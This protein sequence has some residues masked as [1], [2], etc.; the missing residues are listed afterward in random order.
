MTDV[1][2]LKDAR[3]PQFPLFGSAT[4]HLAYPS[5]T[6]AR[7]LRISLRSAPGR[8]E[9]GVPSKYGG[10]TELGAPS[11]AIPTLRPLY[12]EGSIGQQ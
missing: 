6:M 5:S 7:G 2:L 9:G 3:C 10:W 1:H 12:Q 8:S 11:R 4:A